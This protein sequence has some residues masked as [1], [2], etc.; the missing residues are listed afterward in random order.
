MALIWRPLPV[1][2]CAAAIALGG[3]LAPPPQAVA[4]VPCGKSL[5]DSMP[6]TGPSQPGQLRPERGPCDDSIPSSPQLQP[7]PLILPS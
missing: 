2:I 1:A 5:S 4:L 7:P 3:A 6:A